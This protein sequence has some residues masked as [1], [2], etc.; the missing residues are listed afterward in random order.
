M[1]INTRK[2]KVVFFSSKRK[3]KHNK[4]KFYF[5]GITVHEVADYKY[6]RIEF[7][8]NLSWEGC[9]KKRTLGGWKALYAFQNRCR[10]AELWDWKT[11]ET[12]FGI[13]VILVVLY[14][15]D[16]W[17]NNT[18]ELQWKQIEKIK[19]CFITNNF[20]I[21]NSFP[22]DIMLSE[23]GA[24]PIEAIAMVHLRRYLKKLSKWKMVGCL[25]SSSITYCEKER[26]RGCQKILNGLVNGI[27]T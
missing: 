5:E 26:R 11:M 7:N 1:Q 25:R 22:Y 14:G 24:S 21:K 17:A 15:C 8:K 9:R 27:F 12:L 16:L 23:M 2:M 13:L 19:K 4:H 20:E 3:Q 18:S 10:E 6:L